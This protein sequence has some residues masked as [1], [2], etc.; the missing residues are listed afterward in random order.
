MLNG[1]AALVAVV[2]F[3][4]RIVSS[5]D[6]ADWGYAAAEWLTNYDSGVVRRGLGGE[7]LSWLGAVPQK[8]TLVA[9]VSVI[10]AAVVCGQALVVAKACRR[11]GNS[12]PLLVWLV[13]GGP[14]LANLQTAWQPFPAY[15]DQFTFRKEYLGYLIMLV[16][17]LL[18]LYRPD[19]IQRRLLTV[20]AG[21]G[22]T[23]AVASLVHEALLVPSVAAIG[24]LILFIPDTS[25]SRRVRAVLLVAVPTTLVSL[26]FVLTGPSAPG[27]TALIIGGID[28][29]TQE[30]LGG[31][32]ALMGG[33][34]YYWLEMRA[35]DGI[36]FTWET[37]FVSGAWRGWLL[38]GFLTL[39][40]AVAAAW[41]ADGRRETVRPRVVA[42]LVIGLV[43][44]PLFI[45]GADT[46]RWISV[47]VFLSLNTSLVLSSC[48]SSPVVPR[49]ARVLVVVG[50]VLVVLVLAAG[51]PETGD[52]TGLLMGRRG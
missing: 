3:G 25:T 44:A 18:L 5:A 27:A 9:L 42:M 40:F 29:P 51:L 20:A 12:W 47:V 38:V 7:V 8:W 32:D 48:R 1:G 14:L 43:T 52:P 11:L 15:V 22:V 17:A 2:A 45:V 46:G 28:A 35:A 26:A 19:L 37:V 33:S 23:L 10:F 31:H 6:R 16:V 21:V 34:P 4:M 39:A 24:V 30:W 13:P 36:A 50:V 49:P 41:L